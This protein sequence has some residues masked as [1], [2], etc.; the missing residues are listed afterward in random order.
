MQ[1]LSTFCADSVM[2]AMNAFVRLCFANR[3]Y[4]SFKYLTVRYSTFMCL[5]YMVYICIVENYE[6]NY[7]KRYIERGHHGY[8]IENQQPNRQG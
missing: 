7:K 4:T 5:N 6:K 1:G 2:G 3:T 8:A